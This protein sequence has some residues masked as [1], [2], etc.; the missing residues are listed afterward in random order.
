MKLGPNSLD[1]LRDRIGRIEAEI[2]LWRDVGDSKSERSGK[3][4]LALAN[5]M[6][7]RLEKAL[8]KGGPS[9]AE[10]EAIEEA[11]REIEQSQWGCMKKPEL[12]WGDWR[13]RS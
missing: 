4:I 5:E 12:P 7:G 1:W 10:G 9:K 13:R 8:L 11:I 3:K 2:K 6:L